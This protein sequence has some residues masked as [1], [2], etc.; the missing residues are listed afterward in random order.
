MGSHRRALAPDA[1]GVPLTIPPASGT[2]SSP[3]RR[4]RGGRQPA[5]LFPQPA[6]PTLSLSNFLGSRIANYNLANR[7]FAEGSCFTEFMA[8]V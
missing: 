4:Q 5:V 8:A 6:D 7:N 1:F 3:T 2:P